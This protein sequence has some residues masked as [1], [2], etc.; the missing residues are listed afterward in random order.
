M[1]S[2][3]TSQQCELI[4]NWNFYKMWLILLLLQGRTWTDDV[5]TIRR[6][7]LSRVHSELRL[8]FR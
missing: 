5:F 8:T 3:E 4:Q 6:H 2:E 7:Y 1:R